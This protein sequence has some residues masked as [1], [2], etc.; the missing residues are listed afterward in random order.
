M[1]KA[2]GSH[3]HSGDKPETKKSDGEDKEN[4]TFL[5][6]YYDPSWPLGIGIA[7][8]A[9][10]YVGILDTIGAWMDEEWSRMHDWCEGDEFCLGFTLVT[11][12]SQSAFWI[13]NVVL[14]CIELY[15]IPKTMLRYKV[16]PNVRVRA[17]DIRKCIFRVAFNQTILYCG[18]QLISLTMMKARG[19]SF[20]NKLPSL[21]QFIWHFII[22]VSVE[23]IGFYYSHR[24]FHQP[25]FYRHVHKIHHEFTAPIGLASLYCHPIEF[26]VANWLPAILGPV[27]V[28]AHLATTIAWLTIA[29]VQTTISHCGYHLPFLPS[30]EQHDYHHLQFNQNFGLMG[31]L[32]Y[33]H[34]TN[35]RFMKA[36]EYKRNVVLWDERSARERWPDVKHANFA[37]D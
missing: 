30:S 37:R 27:I 2:T 28:Q 16:Q 24:L 13:P 33:L 5:K 1:S 18:I 36:V 34:G 32:D 4:N 35:G 29:G 14:I 22:I 12:I 7:L 8:V 17:A 31:I 26:V 15:G 9:L 25:Y 21:S 6:D 23:E 10:R 11:L 3:R 20:S 19:C